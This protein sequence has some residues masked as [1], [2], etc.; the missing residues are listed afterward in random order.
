ML[1][2]L[3]SLFAAD[4]VRGNFDGAW[5]ASRRLVETAKAS[6]IPSRVAFGLAIQAQNLALAGEL[7]E[8]RRVLDEAHTVEHASD[9]I[10]AETES[11]WPGKPESS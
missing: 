3:S 5:S 8:A 7:D 10:V 6:E 1:V 9:N 4:A 2:A 11:W